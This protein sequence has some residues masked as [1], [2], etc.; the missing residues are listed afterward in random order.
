MEEN[1]NLFNTGILISVLFVVTRFFDVL[2]KL[3]DRSLLFIAAGLL[4]IIYAAFLEKKR[5]KIIG[6]MKK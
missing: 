1:S 4:M 3:L 6:E 5:R 2:W